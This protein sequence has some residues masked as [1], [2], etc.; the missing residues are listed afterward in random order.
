MVDESLH[1][2][3]VN[4]ALLLT[5]GQ[6]KIEQIGV[7]EGRYIDVP[8]GVR[9]P[10]FQDE[11]QFIFVR[12]MYDGYI[13][14]IRRD[15]SA[16]LQGAIVTGNSQIGKSVG[17][18]NYLLFILAAEKMTVIYECATA[19][20]S[21]CFNFAEAS[22]KVVRGRPAFEEQ[23]R[24]DS[25]Y[26]FDPTANE[27][28]RQPLQCGAFTIVAASGNNKHF[29]Q[30]QRDGKLIPYFLPVWTIHELCLFGMVLCGEVTPFVQLSRRMEPLTDFEGVRKQVEN[31][32]HYVGGTPG[33][34]FGGFNYGRK[35]IQNALD[36]VNYLELEKIFT[37]DADVTTWGVVNRNLIHITI[38]GGV[39][40][41]AELKYG[42]EYISHTIIEHLV[43]AHS[44]LLNRFAF[45]TEKHLVDIAWR[46]FER[47]AHQ[48]L[49]DG[50]RFR[51]R[52]ITDEKKGK[53]GGGGGEG[54]Y[55]E[56]PRSRIETFSSNDAFRALS[57]QLGTYYHPDKEFTNFVSVDGLM[58]PN[59][60][61]NMT[62][63]QYKVIPFPSQLLQK[64]DIR[65][66]EL[67][68]YIVTRADL[69]SAMNGKFSMKSKTVMMPQPKIKRWV[70]AIEQ[71]RG[72]HSARVVLP[73][74]ACLVRKLV[75]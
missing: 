20:V 6:W 12:E 32:Y 22:V 44:A 46:S 27:N 14:A 62:L 72:F 65:E 64:F 1:G 2:I 58:K 45:A 51:V 10:N 18:L 52:R 4:A 57:L 53:E 60:G 68:F 47:V 74:A 23:D 25:F 34:L 67:R 19:D 71:K 16:G 75:V 31:E 11:K 17:F 37:A 69:F 48:T 42:S 70:L 33:F 21:Y 61:F 39:L 40:Q 41:T 26:L 9:L 28:S 43:Q 8:H 49:A 5:I 73:I 3:R 63:D 36:T 7:S 59:M 55:L 54:E 30:F 15:K 35:R 24:K 50:G 66:E 29:N 38:G 13:D 56:L